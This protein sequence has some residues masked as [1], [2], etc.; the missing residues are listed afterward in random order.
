MVASCRDPDSARAVPSRAKV[1]K[2]P[3]LQSGKG[4]LLAR[5]FHDNTDDA[6]FLDF[7]EQLLEGQGT[8]FSQFPVSWETLDF[9]KFWYPVPMHSTNPA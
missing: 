1:S 9:A 8:L 7:V 2:S 5:V 3:G 6:T 4:I